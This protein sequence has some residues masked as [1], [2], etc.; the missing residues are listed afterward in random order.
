LRIVSAVALADGR[1]EF[2]AVAPI[3]AAEPEARGAHPAL[4]A[5][6]LPLPYPLPE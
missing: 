4:Q 5:Q 6:P 1:C 3:S 2:L